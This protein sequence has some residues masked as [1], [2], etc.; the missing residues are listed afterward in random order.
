MCVC[1]CVNTLDSICRSCH[2]SASD[3][4]HPA[5]KTTIPF[6]I[7][8]GW[9]LIDIKFY[10]WDII[11]ITRNSISFL[12]FYWYPVNCLVRRAIISTFKM[13]TWTLQDMWPFFK[14]K[15]MD[16]INRL[17][18][19]NMLRVTWRVLSWIFRKIGYPTFTPNTA[20][21]SKFALATLPT[22]PISSWTLCEV[23]EIGG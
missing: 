15:K 23:D 10:S 1:V 6:P 21:A 16:M 2:P 5:C 8:F 9:L 22:M 17:I 13:E 4:D 20:R 7:P 19:R 11:S 18:Q 3:K 14:Q 12:A